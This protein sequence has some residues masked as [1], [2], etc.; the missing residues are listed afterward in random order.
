MLENSDDHQT[1]KPNNLGLFRYYMLII[2]TIFLFAIIWCYS[3]IQI[4]KI[5]F[6]DPRL[7]NVRNDSANNSNSFNDIVSQNKYI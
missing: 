5:R 6:G 4:A 1:S 3:E 7:H 2:I